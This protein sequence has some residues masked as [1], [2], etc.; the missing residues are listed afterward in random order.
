MKRKYHRRE[1]EYYIAIVGKRKTPKKITKVLANE[2]YNLKERREYFSH[3]IYALYS[4]MEKTAA[5]AIRKVKSFMEGNQEDS[6]RIL[7]NDIKEVERKPK[8]E[9]ST[10]EEKK[11]ILRK[12]LQ[13]IKE[14]K[15]VCQENLKTFQNC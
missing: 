15:Q 10:E 6:V 7:F 11:R 1:I 9:P 2:A 12:A 13:Y 3:T 14:R 8:P 5:N 4:V